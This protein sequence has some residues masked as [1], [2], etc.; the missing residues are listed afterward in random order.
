MVG[1]WVLSH[2]R[3]VDARSVEDSFVAWKVQR[4]PVWR[5]DRPIRLR[6]WSFV[7]IG[8]RWRESVYDSRIKKTLGLLVNWKALIN[9]MLVTTKDTLWRHVTQNDNRRNGRSEALDCGWHGE[10][11][12]EQ[13]SEKNVCTY[14]LCFCFVHNQS[15]LNDCARFAPC[16]SVFVRWN[17]SGQRSSVGETFRS[18]RATV[19]KI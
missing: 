18:T 3:H 10:T 15:M 7:E 12:S 14:M 4:S 16:A 9:V 1:A 5:V 2:G 13:V 8:V 19:S 17:C 6:R 11:W